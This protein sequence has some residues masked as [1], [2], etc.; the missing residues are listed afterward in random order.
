[1]EA[2]QERRLMGTFVGAGAGGQLQSARPRHAKL[3]AFYWPANR[4]PRLAG[5]H[6]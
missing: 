3:A 5:H 2:I 1:V 4:A 6:P